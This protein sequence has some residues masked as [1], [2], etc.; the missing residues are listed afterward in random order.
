MG[1]V[2]K[3]RDVWCIDTNYGYGWETESEYREDDYEGRPGYED[4]N[5]R[6]ACYEDAKE[7]KLA[8]ASVRIVKRREKIT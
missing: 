2:R 3:T 6:K 4:Y 5:P 1:Y 7:Y 8:G